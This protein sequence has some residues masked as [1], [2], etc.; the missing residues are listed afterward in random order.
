MAKVRWLTAL[1]QRKEFFQRAGAT[2]LVIVGMVSA[3][4]GITG[5][6]PHP[7]VII[8][9]AVLALIISAAINFRR[10][11]LPQVVVD[12]ILGWDI[13]A[14][15]HAVVHCPCDR[16]LA[17]EA[18]RLA[19]NCF[20]TTFTIPSDIYEQL[21]AKNPYILAC[22][23][24]NNGE[25]LAYFDAIPVTQSFAELFL[26]GTITEEQITHEDVL[27]PD[28]MKSCKHLFIAGLAVWHPDT[29]TGRRNASMLAWAALKYI[30]KFYGS[31]RPATFA[32]A[33]TGTGEAL[34]KRFKLELAC[35]AS[36]RKDKYNLYSL[37]ATREEIARRLA[38][39]PDWSGLCR[40]GWSRSRSAPSNGRR[41]RPR[42][43]P[44]NPR[45]RDSSKSTATGS[46]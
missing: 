39:M 28:M 11:I 6:R 13:D 23:T 38:H 12:D 10:W 9:L 44:T 24:N 32:V 5:Y 46:R 19:K 14:G 16:K 1:A 34:L 43:P 26:R 4:V 20:S 7:F 2:F 18:G 36:A 3:T 45:G 35:A 22:M 42:L 21:R 40:L 31:S 8:L 41:K 33:S 25:F 15:F 29:H 30:D 17:A 37:V 27:A